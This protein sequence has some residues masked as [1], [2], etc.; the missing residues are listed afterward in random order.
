MKT[1]DILKAIAALD[2]AGK[3]LRVGDASVTEQIRVGGECWTAAYHLR[4]ALE[5][6]HPECKVE[7]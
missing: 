2:E 1:A 5:A 7:A 6:E 3:A 4:R